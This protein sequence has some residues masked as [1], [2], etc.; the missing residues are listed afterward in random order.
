LGW[1]KLLI[2]GPLVGG[3]GEGALG[4]SEAVTGRVG[5]DAFEPEAGDC[6]DMGVIDGFD[7][8]VDVGCLEFDVSIGGL[9][10]EGVTM[11][12]FTPGDGLS[13]VIDDWLEG[14]VAGRNG[15]GV[16]ACVCEAGGVGS[17]CAGSMGGVGRAGGAESEAVGDGNEGAGGKLG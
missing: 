2:G 16:T 11:R 3:R 10:G 9:G 15:R 17:G 14:W 8:V 13:L 5:V 1:A 6:L 4:E 7:G 12:G